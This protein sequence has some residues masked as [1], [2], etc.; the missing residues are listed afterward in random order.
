MATKTWRLEVTNKP[1]KRVNIAYL[2]KVK[3]NIQ[4]TMKV[5]VFPLR[6]RQL[7]LYVGHL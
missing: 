3:L 6:E 2:I 5:Q 7:F 4:A 1:V